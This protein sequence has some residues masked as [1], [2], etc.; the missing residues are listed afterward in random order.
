MPEPRKP[1]SSDGDEGSPRPSPAGGESRPVAVAGETAAPEEPSPPESSQPP[2]E[3]G[4]ETYRE[5]SS[6]AI[7][8][9]VLAASVFFPWYR[10]GP[11]S[12][13][14]WRTG[15]WGP[16]IF[17]LAVGSLALVGLRRAGIRVG[18]PVI[19]SHYH[20]FVG[21]ASI[22]MAVL[23]ARLRPSLFGVRPMG[24]TWGTWV[25]IGAAFL[26]A[27]AAGRMSGSAPLVLLP[28]WHRDKPGRLG[29]GLLVAVLAGAVAFG[30][31]NG[32]RPGPSLAGPDANPSAF[33][34]ALPTKTPV[35]L[36][37][38]LPKCAAGFPLPPGATP[39]QGVESSPE[40]PS[41]VF[42]SRTEA[43]SAD[44]L[45]FFQQKLPPAGWKFELDR[46]S[47]SFTILRLTAPKC[48]TVAITPAP[49]QKGNR[50]AVVLTACPA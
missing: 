38:K 29:A 3:A 7:L 20:E 11:F 37:G 15:A 33:P 9:A 5:D 36:Q 42:T 44:V 19:E 6:V 47:G 40:V 2:A 12:A 10:L 35:V 34:T 25:A 45:K 8:A 21:W 41:C 14:G 23:K 49:D 27:F 17:F 26:L 1:R 22:V 18:L 50:I 30:V 28:G 13:S 4:R 24:S 43:S 31:V 48:G 39:E 16:A 32:Y 46:Q